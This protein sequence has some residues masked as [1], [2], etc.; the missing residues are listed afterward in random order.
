MHRVD[1][2]NGDDAGT[3]AFRNLVANNFNEFRAAFPGFVEVLGDR[4]RPAE[5]RDVM[6]L[7]CLPTRAMQLFRG[8]S[9]FSAMLCRR[10]CSLHSFATRVNPVAYSFSLFFV[11]GVGSVI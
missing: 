3:E 7:R 1:P 2:S 6:C 5:V 10:P 4:A 8:N 11:S 9:I